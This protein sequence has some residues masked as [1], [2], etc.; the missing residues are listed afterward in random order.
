MSAGVCAFCKKPG[1]TTL[2]I[3]ASSLRPM[4]IFWAPGPQGPEKNYAHGG[5]RAAIFKN[6]AAAFRFH[7]KTWTDMCRVPAEALA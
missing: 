4:Q 3:P 6:D 5:C 7:V 1:S 2:T